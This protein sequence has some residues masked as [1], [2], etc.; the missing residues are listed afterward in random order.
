[1]G[2]VNNPKSILISVLNW[3]S[4]KETIICVEALRKLDG[5]AG[6]VV[7]LI[8]IDNGSTEG[9]WETLKT[10]LI[11]YD[12]KL[13]RNPKNL[14]F[15]GG[16]NISLQ[17]AIEKSFD[18]IWLMNNDAIATPPALNILFDA[19]E[20]NLNYGAVSPLVL[21][22][23]DESVIDFCGSRH[24]WK[25]FDIVTC[26]SVEE[27]RD[28]EKRYPEDMWLMGAAIL[29]RTTAIRNIGF[30]NDSLFAYY[31]DNDLCTRLSKNGWLN[32]MVFEAVVLH[33]HPNSRIE[34]KPPYYFYLMARNSFIFWF[35]HTPRQYRK[36]IRLKLI[37][38]AI[39]TANRLHS[40]DLHE[41]VD[42][43]LLGVLDS[44]IT[45]LGAWDLNR[46]VPFLMRM[47][48]KA[49]WFNHVKHL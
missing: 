23:E 49:L 28:M 15:A 26:T 8:V 48:R 20:A 16:H 9:D 44:Q 11:P 3:N 43:C 10:A 6:Y 25:N 29:L 19:M 46:R 21:A 38:K 13:L 31:E 27:A 12:V 41:K 5:P 42:A 22:R 37:D 4:A 30:L 17:I 47:L 24:D 36:F 35:S 32:K 7:S 1:M 18:Y 2:K 40:R 14:G 33:R 45:K 34:E 39:L